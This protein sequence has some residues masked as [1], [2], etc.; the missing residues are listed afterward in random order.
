[1]LVKAI[2]ALRSQAGETA[3]GDVVELE[4]AEAQRLI[5]RGAVEAVVEA[6]PAKGGKTAGKPTEAKSETKDGE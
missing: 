5:E 3:P 1:M 6:K 4:D 2:H